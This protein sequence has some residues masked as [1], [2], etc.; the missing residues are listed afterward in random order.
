MSPGE[1]ADGED[2]RIPLAAVGQLRADVQCEDHRGPWGRLVVP[3]HCL[4][5]KGQEQKREARHDLMQGKRGRGVL[6]PRSSHL[7]T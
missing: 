3:Q 1:D 2:T 7:L 5:D 4:Q 6:S